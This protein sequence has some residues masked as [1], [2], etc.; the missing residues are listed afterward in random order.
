MRLPARLHVHLRREF[1]ASRESARAQHFLHRAHEERNSG[2]VRRRGHPIEGRYF[3]AD[4]RHHLLVGHPDE[5]VENHGHGPRDF[6]DL[7]RD[8]D[9]PRRRRVAVFDAVEE[10][11][12]SQPVRRGREVGDR[13]RISNHESAQFRHIGWRVAVRTFDLDAGEAHRAAGRSLPRGRE[14]LDGCGVDQ[15]KQDGRTQ[16]QI[17]HM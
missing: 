9:L 11:R 7:E 4:G 2:L 17:V 13:R 14:S 8:G 10:T 6:L 5:V 12:G 1:N 16:Y 15:R 3:L